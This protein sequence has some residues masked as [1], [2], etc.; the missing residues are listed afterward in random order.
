MN[1]EHITGKCFFR[2]ISEAFESKIR[3]SIIDK[4][5]GLLWMRRDNSTSG[6][7][8]DIFHGHY[9]PI[10]G[11]LC[12]LLKLS[13]DVTDRIFLRLLLRDLFSCAARLNIIGP[14]EGARMQFEFGSIIEAMLEMDEKRQGELAAQDEEEDKLKEKFAAFV[15]ASN[16]VLAG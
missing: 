9:W 3:K 13:A 11:A 5:K 6:E 12:G 8:P 7:T 1:I 4:V 14:L 10:F 16:V 15:G 2:I